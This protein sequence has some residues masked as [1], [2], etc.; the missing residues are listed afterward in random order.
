MNDEILLEFTQDLQEL[1][2]KDV[3]KIKKKLYFL[4]EKLKKQGEID[5]VQFLRGKCQRNSLEKKLYSSVEKL[6]KSIHKVLE[7]RNRNF[8]KIYKKKSK[9]IKKVLSVPVSVDVVEKERKNRP[10]QRARREKWEKKYG[11]DANHLKLKKNNAV[12]SLKNSDRKKSFKSLDRKDQSEKD[13]QSKHP[14]WDAKIK[15]REMEE[16]LKSMGKGTKIIF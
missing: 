4:Q 10:G 13:S 11:Q 7:L 5:F 12:K 6:K 16:K 9:K 8:K 14:S 15:K 1:R 2:E 3:D